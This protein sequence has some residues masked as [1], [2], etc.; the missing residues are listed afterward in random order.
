MFRSENTLT[1]EN[2]IPKFCIFLTSV[3]MNGFLGL[4]GCTTFT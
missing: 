1:K 2:E 4:C 3:V